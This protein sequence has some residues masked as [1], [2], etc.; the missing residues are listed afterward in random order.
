M[1]TLLVAACA[2]AAGHWAAPGA[3]VHAADLVFQGHLAAACGC[4]PTASTS[5]D[6]QL[7]PCDCSAA[8]EGA[9]PSELRDSPW[10]TQVVSLE[11]VR[12]AARAV[13]AAASADSPPLLVEDVAV[14][15][16]EEDVTAAVVD[17]AAAARA[18]AAALARATAV[19]TDVP[20][21]AVPAVP[22]CAP[23]RGT[24]A[25]CAGFGS[26]VDCLSNVRMCAGF[27][28]GSATCVA[29]PAA[30]EE[31]S[32][33]RRSGAVVCT[34]GMGQVAGA[35]TT[36][37]VAVDLSQ[38]PDCFEHFERQLR[39]DCVA[40][41]EGCETAEHAAVVAGLAVALLVVALRYSVAVAGVRQAMT[42]S[43]TEAF[44]ASAEALEGAQAGA[45]ELLEDAMD[46]ALQQGGADGGGG[47][48][49]WTGAVLSVESL[50]DFVQ[51]VALAVGTLQV[52]LPFSDF[53]GFVAP[54]FGLSLPSLQP[55]VEALPGVS[56]S[57]LFW[58]FVLLPSALVT[59]VGV[60][61]S[62]H[63][64]LCSRSGLRWAIFAVST[65]YLPV[66]RT[67]VEGFTCHPNVA[68]RLCPFG[69]FFTSVWTGMAGTCVCLYFIVG[70]P[71]IYF[72]HVRAA[73]R[74]AADHMRRTNCEY[75][76]WLNHVDKGPFHN[77]YDGLEH[78][79]AQF[80]ASSP[81]RARARIIPHADRVAA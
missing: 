40:E 51:V 56:Y 20:D 25:T 52:P 65:L 61:A 77:V 81:Q 23:T 57:A 75:E 50:R 17:A 32:E 18:A 39:G 79:A 2:L 7:L 24:W 22:P 31:G 46:P 34:L 19:A 63:R 71:A 60:A 16:S 66:A 30:V 5:G 73:Q 29:D 47:A 54:L 64:R 38:C 58:S 68:C 76:Y 37:E 4:A 21:F 11:S 59:F 36:G 28:V 43:L 80:K 42:D 44:D 13:A 3:V 72:Y 78:H 49:S 9:L 35:N 8:R 45:V 41:G 27:F 12:E 74:A 6:V 55:L 33:A 1:R 10:A 70:T 48:G 15:Q 69:T 26:C 53:L 62:S 14:A 67:V